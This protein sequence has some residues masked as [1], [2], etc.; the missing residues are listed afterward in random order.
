MGISNSN[1]SDGSPRNTITETILFEKKYSTRN[2][3]IDKKLKQHYR[4]REL[5]SYIVIIFGL[6]GIPI[7]IYNGIIFTRLGD[8]VLMAIVCIVPTLFVAGIIY[9]YWWGYIKITNTRII[10]RKEPFVKFN[11]FSTLEFVFSS[12]LVVNFN[13]KNNRL[14]FWQEDID[15]PGLLI[16]NGLS[17]KDLTMFRNVMCNIKNIDLTIE[18]N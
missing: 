1:I 14:T 4:E 8:S 12:K 18:T 2:A 16:L 10:F 6:S 5:I 13:T 3:T 15:E 17:P 11:V 7:G 9:P